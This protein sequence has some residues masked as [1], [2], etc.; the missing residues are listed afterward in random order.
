MLWDFVSMKL[1]EAKDVRRVI[2]LECHHSNEHSLFM[3]SPS[4]QNSPTFTHDYTYCK[5]T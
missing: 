1:I 4:L 3:L 2:S 5:C